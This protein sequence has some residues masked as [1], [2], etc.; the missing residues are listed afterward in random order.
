MNKVAPVVASAADKGLE[1]Q[2][3]S[4]IDQ[5]QSMLLPELPQT[6]SQEPVLLRNMDPQA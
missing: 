3:Q 2:R 4:L 1:S 6:G 5:K